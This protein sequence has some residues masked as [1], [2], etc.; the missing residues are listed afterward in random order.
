MLRRSVETVLY[1][2]NWAS[3]MGRPQG[4][5]FGAVKKGEMTMFE[6]D[7]EEWGIS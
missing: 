2:L 4:V 1:C 3:S 5:K 7:N 6:R